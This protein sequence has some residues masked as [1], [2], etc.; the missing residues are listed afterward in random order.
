MSETEDSTIHKIFDGL[1]IGDY[2]SVY[3]SVPSCRINKPSP[4]TISI[5][6][7][8]PTDP[9]PPTYSPTSTIIK[10]TM[11]ITSSCPSSKKQRNSENLAS[12]MAKIFTLPLMSWPPISWPSS[13]GL[14][15]KPSNTWIG[16]FPASIST[17]SPSSNW[18]CK[19]LRRGRS[20]PIVGKNIKASAK[21]N[22]SS[23][24]PSS[25]PKPI[26]ST[27]KNSFPPKT[28]PPQGPSIAVA[29]RLSGFWLHLRK[30]HQNGMVLWS[31]SSLNLKWIIS[32]TRQNLKRPSRK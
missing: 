22:S 1:Y 3:V 29:K 26:T 12:S 21:T 30:S 19:W 23:G 16:D 4:S 9:R 10:R 27:T 8:S 24:T 11:T 7:S 17:S 14:Y 2:H 6:P 18:N 32:L 13:N 25:T 28:S 15:S 31:A 20:S 5:L